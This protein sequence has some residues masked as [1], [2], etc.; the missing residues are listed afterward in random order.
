MENNYLYNNEYGIVEFGTELTDLYNNLVYGTY[1][2]GIEVHMASQAGQADANSHITCQNNTVDYYQNVGIVVYG[3]ANQQDAGNVTLINNIVSG[4]Y[5]CGLALLDGWMYYEI[6]HTG[7]YNNAQ[8]KNWEFTEYNPVVVAQDPYMT[9]TGTLPVCYLKQDCNFINAGYEYVEGTRLIGKTTDVN[10]QPDCNYTDLGF[11]YANW[12]FSNP[13]SGDSLSADFDDDLTVNFRDFAV[14]ANYWRQST[15]AEADLDDS[16]FVDY[17]DLALL[18]DQWLKLA[19][20][21]IQ[22]EITG[23]PNNG[24][25][26][27]G[28]TGWTSDTMR[29]FL[30]LN[31]QIIGGSFRFKDDN[32]FTI[33]I[34]K[35]GNGEKQFKII[36]I[37]GNGHLTC[38]NIDRFIFTR[39]LNYCVLPKT[40]E[41]NQPLPFAAYNIGAGDI[42]VKA[43]ANGGNLVWSQSFSGNNIIGSIPAS[44]TNQYELDYVSFDDNIGQSLAKKVTDPNLPN[45]SENVQALIVLPK[46]KFRIRDY[47]IVWAVQNAFKY[48]GIIYATLSG[49]NATYEKVQKYAQNK[50]IKYLYIGCTDGHFLINTEGNDEPDNRR[51]NFDLYDEGSEESY[52]PVVS[53]QR[54][55]YYDPNMAPSWCCDL[56]YTRLDSVASMGFSYLEFAYFDSCYSGRL[57]INASN[58]LIQGQPGQQGIFDIPH[59]DMSFALGMAGSGRSNFYQGWYDKAK[60][61][62]PPISETEYQRW[63]RLE[64]YQLEDGANLYDALYYVIEQQTHFDVNDPVNCYRLKGEGDLTSVYLR[65]W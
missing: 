49:S 65:N 47:Q 5:Y 21:N 60:S 2:N 53:I 8:N 56:W 9:G 42:T 17:A 20:P 61:K 24:Y 22:I 34:S 1:E 38:S 27:I 10:S 62:I 11:H 48:H 55:D 52:S 12:G 45:F 33:D 31:G 37:D 29:I 51:T 59:S 54:S 40:Y 16:G 18:G 6:Q 50:H 14:F 43:Y 19:D 30:L 32:S 35:Y 7:Y 13:G 15:S 26:D 58:Q 57:K 25:V 4:S 64:W 28:I 46:W 63:S 44:I 3:A 23:D 36:S 41:R 39:P